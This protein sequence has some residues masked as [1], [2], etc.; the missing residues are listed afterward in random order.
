[1]ERRDNDPQQSTHGGNQGTAGNDDQFG[2]K[3]FAGATSTDLD[4]QRLQTTEANELDNRH[5]QEGNTNRD[6]PHAATSAGRTEDNRA[7]TDAGQE[8]AD[9]GSVRT[10][11]FD[12][13]N[14]PRDD[15]SLENRGTT[16][17]S[18]DQTKK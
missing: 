17:G 1:M 3:S 18:N 10:A 14:I 16:Q 15:K 13:G 4:K 11:A 2:N 8:F 6:E 9:S 12:E 7:G 5:P